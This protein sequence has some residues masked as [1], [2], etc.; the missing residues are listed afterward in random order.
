MQGSANRP[1]SSN[2]EET[3]PPTGRSGSFGTMSDSSSDQTM[4]L[5]S[6]GGSTILNTSAEDDDEESTIMVGSSDMTVVE[7]AEAVPLPSSDA[8]TDEIEAAVPLQSY[9][10]IRV[11][12]EEAVPLQSCNLEMNETEPAVPLQSCNLDM[13][14]TEAAVPLQSSNLDMDETERAV[15]QPPFTMSLE[16]KDSEI[17][18][19]RATRQQIIAL[20]WEKAG[21]LGRAYGHRGLHGSEQGTVRGQ[22]LQGSGA[23][24]LVCAISEGF[25]P[26]S[27]IKLRRLF[28][29]YP[30]QHRPRTVRRKG[31]P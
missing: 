24:K 22:S 18:Y 25:A 8:E 27:L 19:S 23:P 31:R 17:I 15:T 11:E 14:E 10:L 1:A 2:F 12:S 29:G 6:W 4:D 21:T 5:D 20:H 7:T 13:D 30:D 28:E 9:Y 26:R 3:H 16:G